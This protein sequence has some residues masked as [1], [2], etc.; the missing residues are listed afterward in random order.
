VDVLNDGISAVYTFYEPDAAA[1][2]GTF[3]ILWQIEQAQK[4]V[5]VREVGEFCNQGFASA[6]HGFWGF[7][8]SCRAGRMGFEPVVQGGFS[9]FDGGPNGPKGIV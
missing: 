4:V 6:A 5:I 1:S 3:C 7:Q 2:Y 8:Q 9:L